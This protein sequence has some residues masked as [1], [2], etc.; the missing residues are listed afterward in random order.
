MRLVIDMQGAQTASRHRGIGR[1]AMAL[2]LH[3]ARLRGDHEIILLVNGMFADTVESIRAAF[4]GLVQQ[5]DI[6]VLECLGPVHARDPSAARRRRAA[7]IAREA[8]VASL[9]PDMVLIMSLFEG[10][11]DDAVTSIGRHRHDLPT[12]V[13]LHDL[14]PLIHPREYLDDECVR[15]WYH[16]KLDHLRRADLIIANSRSTAGEALH[17]LGFDESCVHNISAARD[18]QFAPRPVGPTQRARFAAQWGLTRPYALYTTAGDI[19]K[20]NDRLIEA[21]SLLPQDLRRSHQLVLV[22]SSISGELLRKL[23]AAAARAGLMPDDVRFINN[24]TDDDLVW[25]YNGCKVFVFPSWHEGFGL[26]ALEAMA[27]GRAVIGAGLTSLPEVIGR[28]DALFDPFEPQSIASKLAQTLG[29]DGFRAELEAHASRHEPQ[30]SWRSSAQRTWAAL[31][32]FTAKRTTPAAPAPSTARPRMLYVPCGSE[33]S[34]FPSPAEVALLPELSRHYRIDVLA[35]SN[36]P[37]TDG[38]ACNWRSGAWVQRNG[39]HYDRIVYGPGASPLSGDA[40]ALMAKRPGVLLVHSPDLDTLFGPVSG[41][42]ETNLR[43]MRAQVERKGWRHLLETPAW[44]P[45]RTPRPGNDLNVSMLAAAVGFVVPDETVAQRLVHEQP[46]GCRQ[47]V[48]TVAPGLWP[49]PGD[50]RAARLE[51]GLSASDFVICVPDAGLNPVW[52]QRLLIAWDRVERPAGGGTHL[53]FVGAVQHLPAADGR[54][55]FGRS[56]V[57]VT[58]RVPRSTRAQWIDAADLCLSLQD[59]TAVDFDDRC[60][61]LDLLAHGARVVGNDRPACEAIAGP[62]LHLVSQA[63]DSAELAS[64]IC[65]LRDDPAARQRLG[66]AA[67]AF[68]ASAHQPRRCAQTFAAAVEDLY[69][70][71]AVT[72]HGVAQAIADACPGLAEQEQQALAGTIDANFPLWP[73]KRQLLLDVSELVQRDSRSGIQRVVRALLMELI[74]ADP[75]GFDLQPVYATNDAQGYRYARGFTSGFL[76]V[77]WGWEQDDPVQAWPGDVFFGLD[78]QADV[79]FAQRQV[80]Q[81]WHRRGVRTLFLVHDLLPL[82]RPEFFGNGARLAHHR[83]LHTIS[84]FDGVVCVSRTVADEFE[85]WLDVF[86]AHRQRPFELHWSHNGA[87]LGSSVPTRGMPADAPQVLKSLRARP[88]WLMVGTVEPRKAHAQALDALDLLWQQ[89]LDTNLVIVGKQ[90]WQVGALAQRIR[91]HAE[92]GRRLFWLDGISDEYLQA[93]YAASACL[94]TASEGE[95]FGLPLIEAVQHGLPLISRDLPVFRE[96][97]GDFS[98]YFP[99]TTSATDLALALRQWLDRHDSSLHR[100]STGMPSVSWKHSAATLLGIINGA[101][102]YRLW[103]PKP[104]WRFWGNDPR[105]TTEVGRVRNQS[106]L[107]T[108]SAGLL[109]RGVC[110][111]LPAGT[112]QLTLHLSGKR[113]SGQER[114]EIDQGSTTRAPL[115][116]GLGDAGTTP[117]PI[118]VALELS[119]PSNDLGVSLWVTEHSQLSLDGLTVSSATC[120]TSPAVQPLAAQPSLPYS[121]HQQASTRSIRPTPR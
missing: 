4:D 49:R 78:F 64:A 51:F 86:G 18:E 89:G 97:A 77:P 48:Q 81:A 1:Y 43:W 82:H 107:S 120:R 55:G 121:A 76:G 25:L 91:Q 101:A 88:S 17:H 66:D 7:E 47:R 31:E 36:P 23:E 103:L 40:L 42:G 68:I 39:A 26:P 65:A 71:Q 115:S 38:I 37:A 113:L 33:P 108:S 110:A 96:V 41:T 44:N 109:I 102:A 21:W 119:G 57:Q 34:P 90:G 27:C 45:L 15:R 118:E 69:A 5:H 30:F 72:A 75:E 6:R 28:E 29:D 62:A 24:A 80:L 85:A 8:F 63:A 84:A 105:W 100:P 106:M 2:A 61:L 116:L 10:L 67:L 11:G 35:D 16:D 14:I 50:R 58:G 32:G 95:G 104:G 52:D 111:A 73:R 53:V 114:L 92:L 83:W 13:L 60:R 70:R 117:A 59:P 99:D 98:S 79:V 56:G 87:D 94:I 74:L 3:M 9:Q 112:Y 46:P 19:R 54:E 12:A 22:S 20:N 93:V